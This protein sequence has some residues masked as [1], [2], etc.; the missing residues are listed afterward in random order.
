MQKKE[1][2]LWEDGFL[3]IHENGRYF[4]CGETPFFLMGDTAWLLFH[5]L[6]LEESYQYLRNRKELG[7]NVILADLIHT[8][9]Q[10]NRDGDQAVWDADMTKPNLEGSYWTHIDE[11]IQMAEDLG[12]YMG[13]LP[14]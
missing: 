14:V 8:I 2:A 13:I 1:K 6:T 11:V 5:R 7:Y 12:L 4:C 10:V 3:R 9:D